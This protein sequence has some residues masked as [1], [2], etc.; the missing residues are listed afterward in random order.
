MEHVAP[1]YAFERFV[2]PHRRR[3]ASAARHHAPAARSR[4]HRAAAQ[5]ER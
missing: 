4:A 2:M 5:H 3:A 1:N